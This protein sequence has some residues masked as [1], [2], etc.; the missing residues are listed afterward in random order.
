MMLPD[1]STRKGAYLLAGEIGLAVPFTSGNISPVWPPAGVAFAAM[2]IFG[3][4]IWSAVALGAFIVNFFTDIPH[5]AAVGIALG[6]TVGPLYGAWLLQH[7]APATCSP[8]VPPN[9]ISQPLA[10][11]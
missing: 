9:S 7:P 5:V 4:R 3:S 2:L 1:W 8:L 10:V 11:M 6:N